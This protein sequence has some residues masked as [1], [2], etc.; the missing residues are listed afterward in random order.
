[1]DDNAHRPLP[2]WPPP[3]GG[4]AAQSRGRASER[5]RR[6]AG[7]ACLHGA[8]ADRRAA[9]DGLHRCERGAR[10]QLPR[11]VA[12]P[13]RMAAILSEDAPLPNFPASS[14]LHR[15]PK[16]STCARCDRWRIL[17]SLCV[18][19]A[20]EKTLKSPLLAGFL[21]Q[22]QRS[23]R[24]NREKAHR[25]KGLDRVYRCYRSDA[26]WRILPLARPAE[27]RPAGQ[28]SRKSRK[29]APSREK[30]ARRLTAFESEL[31]GAR[32]EP[33][34]REP[35]ECRPASSHATPPPT[36]PRHWRFAGMDSHGHMD[37]PNISLT[38]QRLI[39]G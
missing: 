36:P 19:L 25:R 38:S 4:A 20:L 34:T 39:S 31:R 12:D 28:N 5:G 26:L 24:Q 18:T 22:N 32:C 29:F 7:A 30:F 35:R 10:P 15:C 3:P 16:R 17:A 33:R 1:M 9:G 2:A 23:N 13:A 6:R 21:G 11:L 27:I 8:T 14:G 37:P